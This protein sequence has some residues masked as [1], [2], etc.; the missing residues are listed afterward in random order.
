MH[1]F[2]GASVGKS[3]PLAMSTSLPEL[4]VSKRVYLLSLLLQKEQCK[5]RTKDVHEETAIVVRNTGLGSFAKEPYSNSA[6]SRYS[7]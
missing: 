1:V 3:S 2:V 7:G 4:D 6:I 5:L